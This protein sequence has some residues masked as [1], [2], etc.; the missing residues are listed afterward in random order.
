MK[1]PL[2]YTVHSEVHCI[3]LAASVELFT[4]H[5]I[6]ILVELNLQIRVGHRCRLDSAVVLFID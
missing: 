5:S 3:G 1:H 2:Y 6:N 4:V